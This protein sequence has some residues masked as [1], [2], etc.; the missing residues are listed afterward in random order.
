MNGECVS[1]SYDDG[2]IEGIVGFEDDHNRFALAL[3]LVLSSALALP[4]VSPQSA[5]SVYG[6]G[7]VVSLPCSFAIVN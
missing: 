4:F 1:T 7:N 6:S 5:L 2:I 3:V